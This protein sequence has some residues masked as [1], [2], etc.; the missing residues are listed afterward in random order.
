MKKP[1]T[2]STFTSIINPTKRLSSGS[3]CERCRIRKTKC[4]GGQPC[5]FCSSHNKPCIHRQLKKTRKSNKNQ[6]HNNRYFD[7]VISSSYKESTTASNSQYQENEQFP[8]YWNRIPTIMGK[9]NHT[10]LFL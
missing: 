10:S 4:D 2:M 8:N 5:G 9:N 1:A 3:A 7:T 6:Y